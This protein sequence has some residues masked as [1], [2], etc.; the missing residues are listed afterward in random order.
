MSLLLNTIGCHG[1]NGSYGESYPG[2]R[3]HH[4]TP[5]DTLVESGLI[6]NRLA[7]VSL[8]EGGRGGGGQSD[9][10][11]IIEQRIDTTHNAI[12]SIMTIGSMVEP[13]LQRVD[14]LNH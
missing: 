11:H 1:V 12:V 5:V 8:K 14:P 6:E 13:L 2:S 10:N 4:D 3:Q 7:P 9:L